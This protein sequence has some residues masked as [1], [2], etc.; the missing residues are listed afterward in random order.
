M[1]WKD[2]TNMERYQKWLS[3]P[4]YI[5]YQRS[6]TILRDLRKGRRGSSPIGFKETRELSDFLQSLWV[7]QGG[8]CFYTDEPMKLKGY[9]DNDHHAFTVDRIIPELGYVDGNI[10]LCC[11]IINRIKQNLSIYD[12]KSWVDKI[13]LG[14]FK[15]PDLKG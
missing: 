4:R 7:K 1:G 12:L 9:L 13:N 3:D 15:P 14:G 6:Y 11:N 2:R 8:R 5:F 10:V